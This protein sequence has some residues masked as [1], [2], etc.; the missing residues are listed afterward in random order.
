[1]IGTGQGQ[2]IGSQHLT[3]FGTFGEINYSS[4]TANLLLQSSFDDAV[5]SLVQHSESDYYTLSSNPYCNLIRLD[6]ESTGSSVW[7]EDGTNV[8]PH[9]GARCIGLRSGPTGIGT[10]AELQL[11][12]LDGNN[13]W[14]SAPLGAL[15]VPDDYYVSVWLYLPSD[16]SLTSTNSWYELLN[17]FW[18]GVSG[19]RTAV[20][21][22]RSTSGI[23]NMVLHYEE[24]N[25]APKIDWVIF[26]PLDIS[27]ITGK[28]TKFAWYVHRSSVPSE[29]TIKFWINDVLLVTGQSTRSDFRTK[30]PEG[31]STNW[32]FTFAKSY[33]DGDG[34]YHFLYVDDLQVWDGIP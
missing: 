7:I 1:M 23:Y 18:L 32:W 34:N 30:A 6:F 33:L 11:N 9:S 2:I 10:R 12:H 19:P 3:S 17:L 24:Y 14:P 8:Q 16:W 15:F 28:W 25:Y 4:H 5:I 21:I 20:H 26:D 22:H 13:P 29:A 27:S 31:S